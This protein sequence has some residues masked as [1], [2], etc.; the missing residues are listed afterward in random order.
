LALNHL[1]RDS[2]SVFITFLK[3]FEIIIGKYQK[4]SW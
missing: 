4:K 1:F 3:F 2:N